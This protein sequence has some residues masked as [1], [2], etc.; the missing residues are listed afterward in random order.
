MTLFSCK[1]LTNAL[2]ESTTCSMEI[3]VS[4]AQYE[5]VVKEVWKDLGLSLFYCLAGHC[6][7]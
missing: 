2:K 7:K 1:W 5:Q 4:E 6:S 3:G